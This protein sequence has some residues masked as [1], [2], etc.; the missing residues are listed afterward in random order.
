MQEQAQ[1]KED[2]QLKVQIG[3][4]SEN[5]GDMLTEYYRWCRHKLG[6][7]VFHCRLCGCRPRELIW[8]EEKWL[9]VLRAVIEARKENRTVLRSASVAS[10]LNHMSKLRMCRGADIFYQMETRFMGGNA[11]GGFGRVWP[12]SYD[13]NGLPQWKISKPKET[14]VLKSRM[15]E[16]NAMLVEMSNEMVEAREEMRLE[17]AR[18]RAEL[19]RVS[20]EQH[21][22]LLAQI[23]A[24]QRAAGLVVPTPTPSVAAPPPRTASP[25]RCHQCTWRRGSTAATSAANA[26]SETP[27]EH[28]HHDGEAESH[29]PES[30][31]D[32]SNRLLSELSGGQRLRAIGNTVRVAAVP[33][34]A[35]SVGIECL[36]G[37]ES[38]APLSMESEAPATAASPE[39]A[40]LT[41]MVTEAEKELVE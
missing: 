21:K 41:R 30:P 40:W 7:L 6:A 13:D 37:I 18:E 34:K 38:S 1:E 5:I 16:M 26:S 31:A 28:A 12:R 22:V 19:L 4:V 27:T 14:H 25:A 39:Q 20:N 8:T 9:H 36:Q 11:V 2:V 3:S 24:L 33:S 29:P 32:L 35:A 10:L 23:E 17:A 15:S